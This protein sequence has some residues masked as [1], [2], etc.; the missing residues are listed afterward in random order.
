MVDGLQLE[1]A[2]AELRGADR[3]ALLCG[4]GLSRASGVPTFRGSDGLWQRYRPEELAS[5]AAFGRDPLTVWQWYAWRQELIAGC[6]PNPGHAAVARL[7]GD[8]ARAAACITQN[9]DGLQQRACDE[10]GCAAGDR[11]WELHGCLWDRRCTGCG[12]EHRSTAPL[13]IATDDDLPRCADC[14]AL[15]RPAVVWF[16]EQLDAGLLQRAWQ[17]AAAAAVFLVVGTSGQVEPAASLARVAAGA[18]A[19]VI[20]INPEPTP[21]SAVCRHVLLGPAEVLL[22]HLVPAGSMPGT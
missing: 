5:P 20:E 16:G 8:P 18:G 3:V 2:A 21:L 9:V 10:A 12:R 19:C 11:I 7:L 22:P 14:G 15:E 1:A 17:A 4:A 6:A 13:R